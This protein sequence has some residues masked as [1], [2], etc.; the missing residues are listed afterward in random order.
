[1]RSLL[2][3]VS[4]TFCCKSTQGPPTRASLWQSLQLILCREGAGAGSTLDSAQLHNENHFPLPTKL[5][6]L[7]LNFSTC[8]YVPQQ[9]AALMG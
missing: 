2:G 7:G 6:W 3:T 8:Q 1:M 9:K 4:G 5:P